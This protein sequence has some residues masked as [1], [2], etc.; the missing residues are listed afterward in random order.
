MTRKETRAR[1]IA[2]RERKEGAGPNDEASFHIKFGPEVLFQRVVA[3]L[4]KD[5]KLTLSE[6]ASRSLGKWTRK[7]LNARDLTTYDYNYWAVR[8]VTV[9]ATSGIWKAASFDVK[10]ET[11]LWNV[12]L[13]AD[14]VILEVSEASDYV[15]DSDCIRDDASGSYLF[16]VVQQ[17]NAALLKD[18]DDDEE[19]G[20]GGED[21]EDD[22]SD[23]A[24]TRPKRRAK[25]KGPKRLPGDWECSCGVFVFSWKTRC[26]ACGAL[27]PGSTNANGNAEMEGKTSGALEAAT[28]AG[29][30][31]EIRRNLRF[32]DSK[33]R[34]WKEGDW[35]CQQCNAHVFARRT[36]CFTCGSLK[37]AD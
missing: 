28:T 32:D 24:R 19:Q 9:D 13:N 21:D 31:G 27:N 20:D 30:E 11:A 7:A 1:R 35:E 36:A 23:G 33:E 15:S 34:A 18:E 26:F 37:L 4:V 22:G 10:A 6:K 5:P 3:E 25:L 12:V 14:W 16:N 8:R 2:A 29:P 17:V